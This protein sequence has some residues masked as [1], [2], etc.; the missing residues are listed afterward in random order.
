MTGST[1]NLTLVIS[2][3]GS[4]TPLSLSMAPRLFTPPGPDGRFRYINVTPGRYTISAYTTDASLA[5]GR[6][7]GASPVATGPSTTSWATAEVDVNGADIS[8]LAL[9]MQPGMTVS[10]RVAIDA[11]TRPVPAD[12]TAIRVSMIP[13]DST[14]SASSNGTSYGAPQRSSSA[15]LEADGSFT[16]EG[17]APGTYRVNAAAPGI[18]AADKFWLRSATADDRDALDTRLTI[19]AGHSVDRLVLTLTD[20][21]SELSGFILRR[22]KVIQRRITSSS[23]CRR[24]AGDVAGGRSSGQVHAAGHRWSVLVRRSSGRFVHPGSGR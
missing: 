10:G 7:G 19:T 13:L 6:G 17:L 4:A 21:H 24:I 15:K 16:V 1:G 8:G 11:M 12:L 3:A 9:T 2:G 22:R 14:G 23:C 18:I 20:R 5:G